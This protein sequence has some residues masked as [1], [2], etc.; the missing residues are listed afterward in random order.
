MLPSPVLARPC[1]FASAAIQKRAKSQ[2]PQGCGKRRVWAGL[3]CGAGQQERSVLRSQRA[4]N[5]LAWEVQGSRRI[6]K[7]TKGLPGRPSPASL[8]EEQ[9]PESRLRTDRWMH[10]SWE[11]ETRWCDASGVLGRIAPSDVFDL[12]SVPVVCAWREC[13]SVPGWLQ[14]GSEPLP[15]RAVPADDGAGKIAEMSAKHRAHPGC[16]WGSLQR[17]RPAQNSES[18]IRVLHRELIT[19]M[20]AC[21]FSVGWMQTRN[22][23]ASR[24]AGFLHKH[25]REKITEYCAWL[26]L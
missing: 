16:M 10:V 2:T 21:R 17:P 8:E 1:N 15:G 13:A 23:W 3:G 12:R 22:P 26:H 6:S 18:Q 14:P 20:R 7:T 4:P 19:C 24:Q 11:M 25:K 9:S 5:F